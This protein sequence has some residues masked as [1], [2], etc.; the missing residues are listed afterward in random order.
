M[1]GTKGKWEREVR[2]YKGKRRKGR[3]VEGEWIVREG[4]RKVERGLQVSNREIGLEE[5][6]EQER[7]L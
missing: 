6:R 3:V 7:E 2:V 1:K 5:G 4:D